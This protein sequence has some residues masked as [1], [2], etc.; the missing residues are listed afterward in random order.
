MVEKLG[1]V[2][3]VALPGVRQRGRRYQILAR[4]LMREPGEQV[5][6]PGHRF[7][8]AAVGHKGLRLFF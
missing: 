8:I 4:V 2:G 3:H 6:Q 7:G 5:G 1:A